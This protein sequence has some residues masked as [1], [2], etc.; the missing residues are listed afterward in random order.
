VLRKT[1]EEQEEAEWRDSEEGR[2]WLRTLGTTS[3]DAGEEEA[4]AGEQDDAGGGGEG[5]GQTP[6]AD[7]H[8]DAMEDAAAAAGGEGSGRGEEGGGAH[9]VSGGAIIPWFLRSRDRN[10]EHDAGNS[11]QVVARQREE[12]VAA[13]RCAFEDAWRA[14]V[15]LALSLSLALALAL[16]FL[17][18]L[19]LSLSFSLSLVYVPHARIYRSTSGYSPTYVT[20]RLVA[21]GALMRCVSCSLLPPGTHVPS[22][23]ADTIPGVCMCVC[24]CVCA[25]VCVCVCVCV[26]ARARVFVPVK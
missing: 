2:R 6:N 13:A 12:E 25:C 1:R 17:A 22:S 10:N 23:R 26:C 4:G 19:S 7:V 15:D 9:A 24:A 18:S 20:A 3:G 11:E 14:E 5:G 16:S 8:M 21:C